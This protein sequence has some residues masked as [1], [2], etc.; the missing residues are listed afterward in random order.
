MWDYRQNGS[1]SIDPSERLNLVSMWSK[2]QYR[3]RIGGEG[4]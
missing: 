2:G 4:S 3:V 1:G